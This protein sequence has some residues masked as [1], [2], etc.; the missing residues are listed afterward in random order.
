MQKAIE[1]I[2]LF[3]STSLEA[4]LE[5]RWNFLVASLTSCLNLV[6]SI[7][8]LFLFYRTGYHFAGWSWAEAMMVL[9][10]FILLQGIS[11]TLFEPNLNRIVNHIQQ[12]TLDYILLKPISSQFW[13]S[14]RV[15]SIWGIPDLLFALI[16]MIY[17]GRQ[18]HLSWHSYLLSLLPI[19]TSCLIL[20]SIWY[21]L[22]TT[23]IWFVKVNNITEVLRGVLQAGRYPISAYPVMYRA[24]FTFVI[25]IVF[26]TTVPAETVL[27]R[28]P[29]N[30]AIGSFLLAI[31]LP[32]IANLFWRY[33]LRFYTSASS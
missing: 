4:E 30:L 13:L 24:F 23:S 19:L 15:I 18:L 8:S 16:V 26:L 11:S 28:V 17:S 32:I 33:A 31:V 25:P 1:I 29:T 9:S 22:A 7:F 20:Y 6:G 14:L 2:G 27:H 5:Y 12:G 10:F 21:L 3:W